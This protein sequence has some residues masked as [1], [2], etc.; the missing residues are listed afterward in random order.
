M[1][2]V[3]HLAGHRASMVPDLLVAREPR[4]AAWW[5][6]WI[7]EGKEGSLMPAF[8]LQQGGPLSRSQIVSLVDFA[9]ANLPTEPPKN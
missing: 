7:T 1:C 4:D 3:C 9:L 6:K 8:A 2:G 5:T